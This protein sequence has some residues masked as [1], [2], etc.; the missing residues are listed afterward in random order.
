MKE[1]HLGRCGEGK[2]KSICLHT[3]HSAPA[4][5]WRKHLR[6]RR[7]GNRSYYKPRTNRERCNSEKPTGETVHCLW[8]QVSLGYE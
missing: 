5:V 8:T 1:Q 2:V 6:Q 7:E 4:N 3:V